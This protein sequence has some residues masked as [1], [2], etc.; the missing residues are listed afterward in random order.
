MTDVRPA[1]RKRLYIVP[2]IMACLYL[3]IRISGEAYFLTAN[4]A[5]MLAK[6]IVLPVMISILLIMGSVIVRAFGRFLCAAAITIT[7]IQSIV[8]YASGISSGAD[9]VVFLTV[10][11]MEIVCLIV[12]ALSYFIGGRVM[13]VLKLVFSI[14]YLAFVVFWAVNYAV[15]GILGIEAVLFTLLPMATLGV[16]CLTRPCVRQR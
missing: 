11:S 13:S 5:G 3:A 12:I 10:C 15:R 1:A 14:V 16:F 7:A 6:D 9:D 8:S 2:L 4:D